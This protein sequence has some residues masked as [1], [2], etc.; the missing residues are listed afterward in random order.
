MSSITNLTTGSEITL[1][2][3]DLEKHWNHIALEDVQRSL[4]SYILRQPSKYYA[5]FL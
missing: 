1:H 5:Y 2:S 4:V 3:S